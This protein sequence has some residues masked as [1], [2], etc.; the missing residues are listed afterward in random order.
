MASLHLLGQANQIEVQ[1]DFFVDVIPLA[2]ML[3]SYDV[4]GI[5]NDTYV[6]LSSRQLKYDVTWLLHHFIPLALHISVTLCQLHHQW[7]HCIPSDKTIELM[8]NMNL[9]VM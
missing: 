7:H 2:L 9:F 6:F 1:H 4:N 3:S 8:C 5:K